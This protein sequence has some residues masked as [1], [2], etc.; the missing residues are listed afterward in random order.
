MT[1]YE[2]K[3]FLELVQQFRL[4]T[5]ANREALAS[6]YASLTQQQ[7]GQGAPLQSVLGFCMEEAGNKERAES[8]FNYVLSRNNITYWPIPTVDAALRG[9][10][11]L[12][13]V[14]LKHSLVPIKLTRHML[15]ICGTNPYNTEGIVEI[16][17]A[18]EKNP[19]PVFVLS[20]PANIARAVA[21]FDR[22]GGEALPSPVAAATNLAGLQQD[23]PPQLLSDV[24]K[25][26]AEHR[27]IEQGKL[28]KDKI[29]EDEFM[30]AL[31]FKEGAPLIESGDLTSE[32]VSLCQQ[33][34]RELDPRGMAEYKFVPVASRG[35]TLLAI[36]SC[37]WDPMMVE[38]ISGY[39]PHCSHVRF[40]IASPHTLNLLL[41]KLQ[42]DAPEAVAGYTPAKPTAPP[43]PLVAPMP[44]AMTAAAPKT[45]TPPPAAP[46]PAAPPATS[47]SAAPPAPKYPQPAPPAR[48]PEPHR[49]AAL[50]V[51]A[52]QGSGPLTQEEVIYLVNLVVQEANKIIARKRLTK[53]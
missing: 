28:A 38:V 44:P 1:S 21:Q 19:Y 32:V 13:Q 52:I 10:Q 27:G 26:I 15:L 3:Q 43:R 25:I 46:A 42:G 34:S 39:F 48:Q 41:G 22:P 4:A 30:A 33:A 6:R 23:I 9:N 31:A 12:K 50:E 8:I 36:S 16:Y 5:E 14:A 7:A 40:A 2:R 24:L 37:P 49:P 51:P 45:P 18:L 17:K 20:E 11:K 53:S 35:Q 47:A 29:E